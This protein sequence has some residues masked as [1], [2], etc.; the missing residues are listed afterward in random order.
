MCLA[1]QEANKDVSMAGKEEKIS[2]GFPYLIKLF[3]LEEIETNCKKTT[4]N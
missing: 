2:V 3:V 4:Y 1:F